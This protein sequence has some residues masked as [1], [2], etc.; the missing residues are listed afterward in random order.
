MP[1]EGKELFAQGLYGS[2]APLSP[3]LMSGI[4]HCET[5]YVEMTEKSMKR[6]GWRPWNVLILEKIEDE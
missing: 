6:V 4:L 5:D 2:D 3:G 1:L